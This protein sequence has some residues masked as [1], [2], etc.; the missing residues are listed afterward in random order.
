MDISRQFPL[1]ILLQL[2]NFAVTI[3]VPGMHTLT[4][5][6]TSRFSA[7]KKKSFL[8]NF[9]AALVFYA[10]EISMEFFFFFF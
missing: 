9:I 7:E 4:L 1:R 3:V 2:V 6:A 5:S 8:R 10:G